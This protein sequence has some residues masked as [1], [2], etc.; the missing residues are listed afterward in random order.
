MKLLEC[1]K[2][3]KYYRSTSGQIE[4][5]EGYAISQAGIVKNLLTGHVYSIQAGK[6]NYPR[7]TLTIN[8]K[9]VHLFIS[10]ALCSSFKICPKDKGYDVDHIDRNILN[11]NLDNLEFKTRS[12]NL[13]NKSTYLKPKIYLGYDFNFHYEVVNVSVLS[14]K[15]RHSFTLKI[16]YGIKNNKP[17]KGKIWCSFQENTFIKL[18]NEGINIK[19]ILNYNWKEIYN[20]S[21]VT[22]YIS[23]TGLICSKY[24]SGLCNYS[25]G[26]ETIEDGSKRYYITI[27]KKVLIVSRLVAKYYLN[28]GI[29]LTKDQVV[30]H[31]DTNTENNSVS[32]LRIVSQKEN[33]NNKL[34]IEKLRNRFR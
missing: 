23:D 12:D 28:N 26:N 6:G 5:F 9:R 2:P 11:N 31:I 15:E 30:D 14:R 1:W 16:L 19:N 25:F 10:V 21:L 24:P 3:L 7:V 4:F 34:T 17:Y 8:G 33:M 18:T 32:N 20:S 27:N 13:K 29:D 22:Y